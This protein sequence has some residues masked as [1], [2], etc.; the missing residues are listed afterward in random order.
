MK[1]ESAFHFS[2]RSA[3]RGPRSLAGF[4]WLCSGLCLAAEDAQLPEGPELFERHFAAIGGRE[5]VRAIRT[6]T[7]KGKVA[8]DR[9]QSEF[10]LQIKPTARFLLTLRDASGKTSRVGRDP[11]GKCW[12]QSRSGIGE[13]EGRSALEFEGLSAA[14]NPQSQLFMSERLADALCEPGISEGRRVYATGRRLAAKRV[15]PRVWFDTETGR[16]AGV[17]PARFHEYREVSGVWLPHEVRAGGRIYRVETIHFG[18]E[19]ADCI[20]W[21]PGANGLL[22]RFVPSYSKMNSFQTLLSQTGKLEIVR[23]PVPAN[24]ASQLSKLPA[25]D[26]LSGEHGQVDLRSTD[27]MKAVVTNRLEELLHADFDSRTRWPRQLPAGFDPNR[28]MELCKDPGLGIR[29]LHQK[30]IT[31]KAVGIGIIDTPLLTEHQEYCDRL[32]LYEEIHNPP[33]LSAHM[34][35]TAV[36]S[37]ALGKTCGVAPEAELY[38][39][40]VRNTSPS[41]NGGWELDYASVGQAIERLL[42][43]NRIL[44]PEGRIRVI[45]ISM[46]WSQG[47]RGYETA[48]AAVE[49]AKREGV[50]VISTA[51]RHTY[52]LQ[53]DGLGKSALDD[54]NRVESYGPGFWWA[55]AFWSGE[56]RFKPG[57]RFCVPMDARTTASPSG[58]DEYAHYDTGG[59]SW[60]VPWVSGLYALAC[61]VRPD[62]TPELFWRETLRTGRT[63]QL[64]HDGETIPFG[65]IVEPGALMEALKVTV[66]RNE[67][68]Q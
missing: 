41:T 34:H 45:S 60:A 44:S 52:D 19:L 49:R 62:I 2:L 47:N 23:R 12:S 57:R 28:I 54:P 30:G 21:R 4:V 31:G 15:M 18:D 14:F 46:G 67:M 61:Q 8:E 59:W 16:M 7:V 29:T 53:F 26:P 24:Y 11:G 42:D 55:T 1:T 20:F 51:L 3:V 9:E 35:G 48:M 40:A 5:A 65:T 10:T 37:I 38:F 43:I 68:T 63:I 33:G 58:A 56:M 66:A 17:G 22:G 36:A 27:L 39:I 13:L 50:F 64:R 32:R 25:F 6:V